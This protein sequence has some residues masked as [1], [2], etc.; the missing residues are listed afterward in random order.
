MSVEQKREK[1]VDPE[2]E[3]FVDKQD[4]ENNCLEINGEQRNEGVHKDFGKVPKY[5][6]KYKNEAEIL[7]QKRAELKN[8]QKLPPNTRQIPEE[9]RIKTLDELIET[10]KELNNLLG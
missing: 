7:E 1:I 10:K 6:A 5:L 3:V 2:V 8:K 4:F 9:E